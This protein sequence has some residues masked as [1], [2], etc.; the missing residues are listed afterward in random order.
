MNINDPLKVP[1]TVLHDRN[2]IFVECI[3]NIATYEDSERLG[4]RKVHAHF[5]LSEV[6]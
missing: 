1:E 6:L 4:H 2:D 5:L 3:S